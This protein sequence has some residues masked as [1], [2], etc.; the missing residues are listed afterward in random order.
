M[1]KRGQATSAEIGAR[2]QL[3]RYAIDLT[4][5]SATISRTIGSA[6]TLNNFGNVA[7]FVATILGVPSESTGNKAQEL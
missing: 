4:N 1:R 5:N 2:S 6:G 3:S 7:Q